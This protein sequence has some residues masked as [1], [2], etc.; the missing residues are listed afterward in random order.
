MDYEY[1]R[2][3]LRALFDQTGMTQKDFAQMCGLT[4]STVTR[5]LSG[6]RS[7]ELITLVKICQA[8][9]V[10]PSFFV[11]ELEDEDLNATPRIAEPMVPYGPMAR[12]LMTEIQTLE[13]DELSDLLDYARFRK[14]Q[15]RKKKA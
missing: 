15:V 9:K 5:L 8:F 1:T 6:K 10:K 2:N 14:R 12:A 4:Q 11:R 13:E 7:P 3:K